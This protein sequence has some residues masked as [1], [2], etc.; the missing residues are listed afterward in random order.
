[1]SEFAPATKEC[2]TV[3]I[4]SIGALLR[5][6]APTLTNRLRKFESHGLVTRT[7]YAEIAPRVTYKLT[8][9]GHELRSVLEAMNAWGSVQQ[10]KLG[11]T[12]GEPRPR[13]HTESGEEGAGHRR[14][15]YTATWSAHS[16]TTAF[17]TCG[18]L[19]PRSERTVL[20]DTGL[21]FRV[22][23]LSSG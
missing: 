22:D 15:T 23:V 21:Q 4:R 6:S 10:T 20:D 13:S 17:L 9:V 14:G 3:L 16:S 2:E 11:R 7:A 8:Q 5:I 1:M 19:Q 12:A 18:Q